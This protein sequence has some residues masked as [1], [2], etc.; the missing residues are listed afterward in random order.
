MEVILKVK[1]LIKQLG[2]FNPDADITLPVS[3]DI[4][5]SWI[6]KDP[7]TGEELSRETT[8]QVFIEADDDCASCSHNYMNGDDR[9]CSYYDVA[10][11]DVDECYQWENWTSQYE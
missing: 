11:T 1:N 5:L 9:W 4:T 7:N 10:C 3:E 2:K 6:C 8:R